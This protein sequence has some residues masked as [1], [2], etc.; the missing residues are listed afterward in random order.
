ME[1]QITLEE[2]KK[3]GDQIGADWAKVDLEQFQSG[4]LS[5]ASKKYCEVDN[6][7]ESTLLTASLVLSH[8]NEIPDYYTRLQKMKEKAKIDWLRKNKS[9]EIKEQYTK[10]VLS[11]RDDVAEWKNKIENFSR[12]ISVFDYQLQELN[13]SELKGTFE[14]KQ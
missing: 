8:L 3:I 14:R 10:N 7:Y 11:L 5:E 4:L 6:S 12:E 13:L 2:I 9:R 1:P